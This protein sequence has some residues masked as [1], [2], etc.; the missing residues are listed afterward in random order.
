[1]LALLAAAPL[2]ALAESHDETMQLPTIVPVE[3]YTCDFNDGKTMADLMKVVAEWNDWADDQDI[4]AYY[5]ALLTPQFFGELAFD[6][7]WLGAAGDGNVMGKVQDAW[8]NKGGAVAEMFNEVI[9]CCSHTQFAS[10]AIRPPGD[11]DE[12]DTTFVLTFSNC[13]AK[14]GKNF[15][16][17]M[18]GMNAW[19][20]HQE[21]NGFKNATWMMFPVYG[22]SDD[23][24]D[25]K[26]VEGYDDH[27]AFGS[28]F[29]LMGNGGHWRKSGEIFDELLDCDISRV[30]DART[31]REMEQGG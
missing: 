28:D 11:D 26:V 14:D 3:T 29:E 24:Y 27:T 6:V 22:E 12:D 15:S 8:V 19:A 13:S 31:V 9:S 16:D 17:V 7:G 2:G 30:Y 21:E 10:M 4:T 25:F 5:A 1:M 23:D 18:D 20:T